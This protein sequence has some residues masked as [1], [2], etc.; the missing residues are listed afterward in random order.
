MERK[1]HR[2]FGTAWETLASQSSHIPFVAI[3][4]GRN[5]LVLNEI[6]WTLF[7]V[8]LALYA[9]VLK[10]HGAWFGVSPLM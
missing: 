5:R 10:F 7:A 9:I 6:N 4:T 2:R 3:L 1:Y 8:S